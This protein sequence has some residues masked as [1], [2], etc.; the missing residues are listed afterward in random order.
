MIKKIIMRKIFHFLLIA[1]TLQSCVS[2]RTTTKRESKT[3][4]NQTQSVNNPLLQYMAI[5][6]GVGKSW[7]GGKNAGESWKDP[8]G[9]QIGVET[10]F[11]EFNENLS[12]NGGINFSFQGADYKEH[13]SY[14]D[15]LIDTYDLSGKV[16]LN[17]V[18]IPVLINYKTNSGFYGETGLQPGFLVRARDKID[19]GENFDSKEYVNSFELALPLGAGYHINDQISVGA[20][21]TIGLT[22]LSEWGT[23]HKDH[24]Y[25]VMGVVRYNFGSL[26]K[27]D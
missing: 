4:T 16:C 10:K 22:N 15:Y 3:V 24:N 14:D 19:G 23:G 9:G 18:N 21:A 25:L 17:Y 27:T 5:V 8:V 26:F 1:V 7:I 13:G 12:L 20:R 6:L 2:I 11:I